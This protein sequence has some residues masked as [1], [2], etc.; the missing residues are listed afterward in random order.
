MT[1]TV[2][3]KLS[4][5]VAGLVV[6]V[7]VLSYTAL[8]AISSLGRTLDTAAGGAVR[9]LELLAGAQEAFQNMKGESAREQT[10]YS[11][12]ATSDQT[13]AGCHQPAPVNDSIAKVEEGA[14]AVHRYTSEL[15]PL[16]T[17][18]ADIRACEAISTGA[19]AWAAQAREFLTLAAGHRF[20]DAHS[21][22]RDR[23]LPILGDVD[24]AAKALAAGE[25]T[26]LAAANS[27]AH[28][29]IAGSRWSA[30]ALIALNLAA[31][32]AA[33]W[34]AF[35]ITR[36]LRQSVTEMA[37]ASARVAASAGQVTSASQ[38]LARG[39]AD[40]AA[41]LQE[42]SASSE[43]IH[44]MTRRNA[45]RSQAAAQRM[46]E[47]SARVL[48]AN[49]ALEEMLASMDG[50]NESSAAIAR[51][52]RVID[53][54]A[55]QTNILALNAAVEAARAG[56]AGMGFAVVAGEVRNLA[57]RSA[58]AARD[59]AGLIEDSIAKANA[60]KSKLARVAEAVHAISDSAAK[61]KVMVDEVHAASR[62]Q[63]LGI[64]Q[65]AT[66][67]ARIERVTQTTAAGAE[68]NSAASADLATQA[69][70][71]KLVVL[72]LRTMTDGGSG[73]VIR[74][75]IDAALAAHAAWNHRLR[76]AIETGSC[77]IS[78]DAARNDRG[79][80]FGTWLHGLR[81]TAEMRDIAA[82]HQRFHGAAASV[83]AAGLAGDRKTAEREVSDGSEFARTSAALTAALQQ[84]QT[85]V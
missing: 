72:R 21:V 61:V 65:M 22:L 34:V 17:T 7:L 36:A 23:M 45:D 81:H 49:T 69:R 68:Q 84:W 59:T 66:A 25:R 31:A 19:S 85:K 41:S 58:Q 80:A 11:V 71:I 43:E 63:S 74:D 10:A 28:R 56:E 57:Q 55:F 8:N 73:A 24:H 16:L 77:E 60:G 6:S 1:L 20:D 46:E 35:R 26:A 39:A 29:E 62:E 27:Q 82:L 78:V 75:Q 47:A 38:S 51:I 4:L 40:Q 9:K 14:A 50:I 53:E 33:L 42:T 30:A 67:I 48:D 64:E 12:G 13:C 18:E 54:I 79:C 5:A 52:I 76:V 15:R 70:A 37:D 83:L 3:R 2:G 32:M 44:S